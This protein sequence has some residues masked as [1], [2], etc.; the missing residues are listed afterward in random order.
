MILFQADT[1]PA[2]TANP[3][4]LDLGQIYEPP[5]VSFTFETVGWAILG[6]LLMMGVL[7]ILFFAIRKYL[8]NRYRREALEALAKLETDQNSFPQVLVILK[9]VAMQVFGRE[10]VGTLYGSSWLSF[11]DKTG[12]QVALLKYEKQIEALIYQDKIPDDAA[13]REILVQAQK[14]I[15][16]H[17]G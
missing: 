17:A 4:N 7:V 9:R 16:T 15:K 12:K 2:N 1:I 5:P 14:W 11:L 3:A 6:G 8:R 10:K 13:R